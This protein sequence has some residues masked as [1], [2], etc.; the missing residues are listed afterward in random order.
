MGV[1]CVGRSLNGA[2]LRQGRGRTE[3]GLAGRACRRRSK[4]EGRG[5]GQS[6][7]PGLNGAGPLPGWGLLPKGGVAARREPQG[8]DR[9][10]RGLYG[11]GDR[12][13]VWV[14]P[15]VRPMEGVAHKTRLGS[16]PWSGPWVQASS[17]LT[18]L[19]LAT[20]LNWPTSQAHP[21]DRGIVRAQTRLGGVSSGQGL[22]VLGFPH[23]GVQ[24]MECH[25]CVCSPSRP[26]ECPFSF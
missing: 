23:L 16:S 5:L 26:S 1:A 12:G 3:S 20:Y 6:V 13:V 4:T 19:L 2:G 8:R 15:A 24:D 18:P 25:R 17:P 22:V 10:R 7:G 14:E 9:G 11:G 21:G